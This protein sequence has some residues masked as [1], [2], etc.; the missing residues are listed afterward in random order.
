MT[1]CVRSVVR[2]MPH[3]ICGVVDALGEGR[4]RLRRL[5]SGLHFEARPSRWCVPSSRGGV[6]VLRRPSAKPSRSSVCDRPTDGASPTRP[7][8]VW[9]SPMWIRPRRNVPVVSTTAP[10]AELAAV[11]QAKAGDPPAREDEIVGLPL[12]HGEIGGLADR[13]LHRLGIELA[14]RL[15]PRAAYRRPLA[16]IEDAELDTAAVGHP[17][18]QPV[19]RID[20]PHQMA[21]AEPA[22]RRI[23]RHRPDGGEPV[24]HQGRRGAHA[25]GRGRGLAAGV[26]AADHD[27]V[28]AVHGVYRMCAAFTRRAARGSKRLGRFTFQRGTRSAGQSLGSRFT[29]YDRHGRESVKCFT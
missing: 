8:G 20:L 29:V 21:L 22:D 9:R 1:S 17:A 3:W 16:A 5:V 27:D 28:E 7:A 24:R 13:L 11:R 18:H 12:D 25:G 10:A 14:V 15:R 6:P 19:E 2:V 26:A 4:E 23:A